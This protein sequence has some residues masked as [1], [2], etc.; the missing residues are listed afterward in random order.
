MSSIYEL[1]ALLGNFLPNTITL[2]FHFTANNKTYKINTNIK[3]RIWQYLYRFSV[4]EKELHGVIYYGVSYNGKKFD[5]NTVLSDT[6]IQK[7][8]T[9]IIDSEIFSKE[10]ED[11]NSLKSYIKSFPEYETNYPGI[12]EGELKKGKP[13][14]KGRF[15]HI[16]GFCYE[17]EWKDGK[18]NGRGT[19]RGPQGDIYE[20]EFKDGKRNGKGTLK[21]LDGEIYEGDWVN[22]KK[23]GKGKTTYPNGDVYEGDFKNGLGN[24]K[25]IIKWINGDV[26]E[27]EI[28]DDLMNGKGVYKWANGDIYEGDFLKDFRTGKGKFIYSNGEVYEGNLLNN[29]IT[30]YGIYKWTSG[31]IYEGE[32]MNNTK[33]GFGKLIHTDGTIEEGLWENNILMTD[34]KENY[35]FSLKCIKTIN[36]PNKAVNILIQ[37]KDGRLLSGS[38]DGS[39]NIHNKDSYEIVFSIKEHNQEIYSCIQLNDERIVTCSKDNTLKIIKLIEDNKYIVESTLESHKN[40][41]L[42]AIQINNN[43]IISV[44]EDKTIKVWDLKTFKNIKTI[45]DDCDNILKINE[46]EFITSSSENKCIKFWNKENY[47]NTK[48]ISDLEINEVVQSMFL[49][50]ENLL[51]IGGSYV[52]YL[53]DTKKYQIVKTFD[54]YG[55]VLSLK[56]CLNEDILCSI[57][58]GNNNNHI[59]IYKF[60][61][62][63]LIKVLEKK[64]AHKNFIF[65]CIELNNGIIVTAEGKKNADSYEIKF[66]EIQGETK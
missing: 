56:K 14:G 35:S 57:F 13:E 6:G 63:N 34:Y 41:V 47:E 50:D 26:F 15:F 55:D 24:G 3:D 42:N 32:F 64:K 61:K 33:D 60:D 27:G 5:I 18:K 43:E 52:I 48:T 59:I 20:G 19:E 17:G 53:I 31:N 29:K 8:D 54:L 37:L 44:S 30:G 25:G 40:A 51:F 38:E 1:M 65:N 16:M 58:N 49:Y 2:N 23:H 66:W 45:E 62:E 11:D 28:K 21:L 10:K 36:N 7:D 46:N 4:N 12:Y 9:L 22:D 39:L